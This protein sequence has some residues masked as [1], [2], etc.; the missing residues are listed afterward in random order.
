[1]YV[2]YEQL[3]Q[4]ANIDVIEDV[5]TVQYSTSSIVR[6]NCIGRECMYV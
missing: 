5:Y 1:M 4:G 6:K 2:G 3:Q